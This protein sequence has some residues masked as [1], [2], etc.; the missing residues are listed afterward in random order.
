MRSLRGQFLL[1]S[2]SLRDPNFAESVIFM[3]QHNDE[4][5]TGLII[6][7]PLE[8]TVADA[9]GEEVGTD[10]QE[11]L[12]RGG[13]CNGPMMVLHDVGELDAGDEVL[14]GIFY[15]YARVD[16][17]QVLSASDCNAVYVLG[18]AGWQAEQLEREMSEGSWV[19]SPATPNDVFASPDGLWSRLSQRADLMKFLPPDKI[20]DDP[21][22]N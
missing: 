16:I 14:P 19:I 2:P 13:P 12:R 22:L 17:E 18:Y 9:L 11:P 10:V 5:A 15:T 6:N 8:A 21:D 20:P 3:L 4:G 7:A 1:A